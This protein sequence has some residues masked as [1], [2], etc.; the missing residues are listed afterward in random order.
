M[1]VSGKG[2][3]GTADGRTDVVR[4]GDYVWCP[5]DVSHWHGA[6]PDTAMVH[7]ALTNSKNGKTVHWQKPVTDEEYAELAAK[8]VD[9]IKK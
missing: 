9:P 6:T 1:I 8:A 3:V 5:P 2:L 4:A 7:I